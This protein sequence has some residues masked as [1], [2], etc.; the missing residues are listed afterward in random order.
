M[1]HSV[2]KYIRRTGTQAAM[3]LVR[4]RLPRIFAWLTLFSLAAAA[5]M[6]GIFLLRYQGGGAGRH[7]P[8]FLASVVLWIVSTGFFVSAMLA[9]GIDTSRR[10]LEETVYSVRKLELNTHDR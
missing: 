6:T 10:L 4:R 2:T 1:T 7:L 9:A 5:A 3:G 8:A